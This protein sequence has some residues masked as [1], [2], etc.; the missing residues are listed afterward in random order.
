VTSQYATSPGGPAEPALGRDTGADVRTLAELRQPG[1]RP[2]LIKGATILSQDPAVG[3]YA[4]GDILIRDGKIAQVGADLTRQAAEAVVIDAAGT[5]AVPGF[6]DAHV[7][8]WEGQLR[9]A[10]PT[11]DFGGYLGFTAFGYGPHYRPHDN[12]TGTLATA[13][14][15]LDAG[16]TTIIDNSHNSRTPEHSS[17][18]VEAL[19]DSGIRGVHASGAPVGADLPTWPADV[20]RLRSEYFSSEDQ[21]VTLR[22]FDVYPSAD[23]W[24]FAR[25]EGLWMSNEMGSHIDNVA[26]VLAG[27]AAKGLLTSDHAFNHCNV[28][29]DTTWE[30]IKRSGAADSRQ[31]G[32]HRADPHHRRQH[33]PRHQRGRDGHRLRARRQRRHR[34]DRR[35]GPQVA[36]QAD[37]P[38]HEVEVELTG[39]DQGLLEAADELSMPRQRHGGAKPAAIR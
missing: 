31:G 26:D 15:A 12:Y 30:L 21:L 33:R 10:A 1:G 4:T 28:L 11:L 3:D 17:A 6:V 25:R 16:I 35:P 29:P 20:S 8:A 13:L 2:V 22:L 27:L 9:G 18:A 39:G 24:E 19:I 38:R 5:I 7:H 23:L 36:R 32:R 14:V 37:R 34:A